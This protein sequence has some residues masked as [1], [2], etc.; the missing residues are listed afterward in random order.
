MAIPSQ[1]ASDP[2]APSIAAVVADMQERLDRHSL[3]GS[4]VA[5]QLEDAVNALLPMLNKPIFPISRDS[6]W[7]RVSGSGSAL[8]SCGWRL[9]SSGVESR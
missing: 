4:G 2:S 1:R 5:Q 6:C 3:R 8:A 9:I 7:P